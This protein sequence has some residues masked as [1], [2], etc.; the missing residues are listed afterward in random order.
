M[1]PT[2]PARVRGDRPVPVRAA[3]PAH[4]VGAETLRARW[5]IAFDA[6]DAAIRAA[7]GVLPP[8]ELHQLAQRLAAERDSTARLLQGYLRDVP[9]PSFARLPLRPRDAR[10]LLGLPADVAAC[11]FNLDGVLI[12]S[13]A[14]HAEAWTKTFDRFLSGRSDPTRGD[15]APFDPRTDYRV[16]LH[17]KPRL[18]GVRDFLASRGISLPEGDAADEPGAQ[19][20]HGL[21]NEKNVVLGRLLARRELSAYD[22]AR[23]YLEIAH[24]AHVRCAVVSASVN[25]GT[26]LEQTGL[27]N[28]VDGIVD[29]TTIVAEGLRPRPNPD[30]LLA[31]CDELEV[32]PRQTAVFETTPAGIEAARTA[33]AGRVIGVG[34]GDRI[35]ELRASGADLVVIGLEELLDLADAA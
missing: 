19:T 29:G 17:G 13:A 3:E 27:S 21:A 35:R 6:A 14:I 9:A 28:L 22:G 12:G 10:R 8:E 5:R 11:V 2:G 30:I 15:F 32:P 16:H 31:A 1:A 34:R 4:R 24:D 7:K 23:E 33:G 25:T 26:I 20:V 18:E